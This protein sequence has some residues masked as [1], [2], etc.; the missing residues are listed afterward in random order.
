MHKIP[1]PVLEGMLNARIGAML[2]DWKFGIYPKDGRRVLERLPEMLEQPG[3]VC[4]GMRAHADAW[5]KD[6][7][8]A[9]EARD[10]LAGRRRP[11]WV[12]FGVS[13]G[14]QTIF[15][16]GSIV[17]VHEAGAGIALVMYE[18]RWGVVFRPRVWHRME[19]YARHVACVA[20]AHGIVLFDGGCTREDIELVA[21]GREPSRPNCVLWVDR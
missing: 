3:Y 16:E 9:A 4:H 6:V 17:C 8:G 19:R 14:G 13:W 1:R 11:G 5:S 21:A 10:E 18:A 15:E 12:T 2:P 20:G 7:R